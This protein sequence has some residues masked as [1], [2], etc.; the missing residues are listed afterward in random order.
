MLN[1]IIQYSLHNRVM[2]MLIT[3]IVVL[4]GSYSASRMEVDVFPDLTAPTV[5][6][7]TEAKGMASEEVERLVTFPIE[8]ALNGATNVRRVRSSSSMG[9]SVIWVEFDWDTD[10]YI[11]RQIVTE[12]LTGVSEVLP[13]GVGNPTLAPQSSL[14]GEVMIAGLT[15]DSLS[16]QELRS[17]ADWSIRPRLLSIGGVAQVT[18]SGGQIREYQILLDPLKMKNY[19][20]TLDEVM[21]IA[22]SVNDNASGGILHQYSNEYA[23][24]GIARTKD[25]EDIAKSVIKVIDNY[26]LTL[27][28]VAEV[29]LG[30][31]LP[32]LGEAS[33]EGKP[34]VLISITKQPK[35][36]TIDLVDKIEGVFTDM[37]KT[38]P[39][40]ITINSDIFKQSTFINSS[41]S[42]IQRALIEG[43]VFV[44]IILFLF[45]ANVR[46]TVISLVAI[47]ISLLVSILVL[48]MFGFTL[49]TM[50]LGGMAI[51]IGSLVDDAIIDVENVFKHLRENYKKPKDEQQPKLTVV[52]E[53]SKEIRASI[54]NATL[55]IIVTFIP[56][57]FLSGMEGR[58]LKPLGISFI[59]SLFASM[60]VAITLTPVMCS[61]LL[62]SDKMLKK[63]DKEPYITRKLK[64]IYEKALRGAVNHRKAV[65]GVAISLFVASLVIFSTLGR[66]FLPTFNEGSLS[67]AVATLPGTSLHESGRLAMLVEQELLSLPEVKTIAR[68]SGRAELDEHALGANVSEIDV[69]FELTER[70]REEFFTDVRE[71]L[72][73]I[74]GIIFEIGQPISHR[75]D[76][77][78]SG[79]RSNV[80]IKVFGNDLNKLF[81]IGN[82]IKTQIN[83]IDGLVDVNVEQQI[84]A[85][86][87]HILPK[88]DV[89]NRLGIPIGEFTEL[90]NVA[91]AGE[92]VSQVYDG[93]KSY[94]ITVK[95]NESYRNSIDAIED[96]L[97]DSPIS[98]K[99][100]LSDVAE[101]KSSSGPYTIGREGVVRKIV[102]SA[103]V[104]GADLR[105]VVD[106]ISKRIDENIVMGE[107]YF[108]EYG[109]Q[110][111]SEAAASRTL[112]L[113]SILALTVVFFLLFQEFKNFAMTSIVMFNLPFA[114]IGGIIAVWLTSAIIS[115]PAIIGFISLFGIATRNGILLISHYN[116]L[117]KRG[118]ELKERVIMGSV[119]RL[120]PIIM[121]ALTSALAL[122][123][124]A[125][126]GALPGNE[127][128]SPMAIV[129]LGGLLSATLLN[130]FVVPSVYY[131]F[132]KR[133]NEI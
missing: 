35:V 3:M 45:L 98:G 1:K 29:K 128:Q 24:R 32:I 122:I 113:T 49:N 77:L 75:M 82:S 50:S 112:F 42:N 70:S 53:A 124:L 73:K 7:M 6:V 71:R 69:P 62:T 15:S 74:D 116:D 101:I 26:P 52:F 86:E 117:E 114:L 78:L 81:E 92:P 106:E 129:I 120:N 27:S 41:I 94:D 118:V 66:S 20:V 51:A 127:I 13:E 31:K 79:T 88:R 100:P 90:I 44:F 57:F 99:V 63:H 108:V 19:G 23:I 125:I 16:I 107:G 104:E 17:I 10:I 84:E 21:N 110:F 36:S 119:D 131:I 83:D 38:L 133:K 43:G 48:K 22:S 54:F 5:V 4:V 123:P 126:N 8:T 37:K 103:N 33:V 46:T 47:P 121:T 76:M 85:P 109:G 39:S 55:I 130:I 64:A 11:A 96:I 80:A 72:S 102:V 105:G 12:K 60:V 28:D 67:V 97:I 34:A 132:K 40:S 89:L 18:I 93:N 59:V 30:T 87:I 9:F 95:F 91:L 61:Y 68:K 25:V 65:V 14:L 56:L 111:E 58:M 2:V 115:I